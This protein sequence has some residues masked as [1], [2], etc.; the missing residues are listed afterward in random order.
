MSFDRNL[1]LSSCEVIDSDCAAIR[2]LAHDLMVGAD[3]IG[4][5][6]A[7]FAWVRDSISHT[8]DVGYGTVRLRASEVLAEGTG[9]CFGKSHLLVALLRA[10]NVPAGLC[11]QR[12]RCDGSPTTFVLHGLVGVMLSRRGFV[13]IDPRGNKPGV[14]AQFCPPGEALAFPASLPGEL[15]LPGVFARPLPAVISAFAVPRKWDPVKTGLPD[16]QV[17]NTPT[18]DA[19]W[20]ESAF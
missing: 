11:Y 4:F 5:I 9:L 8:A 20:Q 17:D 10:A 3:D 14:D 7:A 12:L 13:R 16:L 2:E 1:L 18:P 6:S 15:N 19:D